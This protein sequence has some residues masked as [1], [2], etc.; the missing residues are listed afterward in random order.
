MA[1]YHVYKVDN[2]KSGVSKSQSF[3]N[4]GSVSYLRFHWRVQWNKNT[5]LHG[6]I[7]VNISDIG[8]A[9]VMA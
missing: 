8:I 1:D 2:P 7:T 6:V 5:K 9:V 4:E 3:C